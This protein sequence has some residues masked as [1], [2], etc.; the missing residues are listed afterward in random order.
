MLLDSS[1]N[2][3]ENN[4]VFPFGEPWL[5]FAASNNS[6]KF[7]TYQHDNDAGSDL[8]YA[9]ARYYASRSGRFRTADP[10]HVGASLGDPQGWNAYAYSGNDPVNG[11]DPLGLYVTR[12]TPPIEPVLRKVPASS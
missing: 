7:T 4:R 11:V 1:G 3:R 5:A 10:G 8:D 2:P 9:M 6:E 12:V